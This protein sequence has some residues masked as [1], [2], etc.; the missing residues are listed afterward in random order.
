MNERVLS[1]E[2]ELTALALARAI[3]PGT[4]EMAGADAETVKRALY[5]LRRVAPGSEGA[6]H[7][8]HQTLDLLA[9][10]MAGGPIRDL[11]PHEL[12]CL[13]ASF[14]ET[15]LTANLLH[16]VS[17]VY[18][19]VHFDR[20]DVPGAL[21]SPLEP[22][23]SG[24]PER[25][26][27]NAHRA[28]DL[29]EDIECDVVVV[30]TG[31]GG[32]VVGHK[33]ASLGHAVVF[34]EEGPLFKRGDFPG[35]LVGS[36]TRLYRTTLTAGNASLLIPRGRLVGGSTAVNGGSTFRPP[37][38][39]TQRWNMDLG[40]NE[41]SYDNLQKYFSEVEAFLGVAP[42]DD[43]AAGPFHQI[44][45]A[46][47]QRLGWHSALML[48]N[49][50]GCRGEGFCDNGC[51]SGARRSMDVSYIPSALEKGALLLTDFKVN[52]ILFTRGRARGV[53]GTARS[54]DGVERRVR[55]RARAVVLACGALATPLLLMKTPLSGSSRHLGKHLT[56]HPSAASL[57]LFDVPIDAANYIPQAEFSS[58]FVHEGLLLV[59]AQPDDHLIPAMLPLYGREL[60]ETVRERRYIG[61][62]GFLGTDQGEGSIRLL[63]GGRPLVS[64]RLNRKD[65]ALMK[66]GHALLAR[67]LFASGAR[68]VYPSLLRSR[69]V[70]SKDA[71]NAFE[72]SRLRTDQLILTAFHPLGTCR[73]SP[74]EQGGVVDL[75]H[76]VYGA[77]GLFIADGSV[78]RGPLGV[79]P[80]LSIM[81]WSLRAAEKIAAQLP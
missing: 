9:R 17:S 5:F 31:A 68:A 4:S 21:R 1:S 81:A 25:W 27:R 67:L 57:G 58:Q 37:R 6:F 61:G 46:G 40:S 48:R 34:V 7:A 8:V 74:T 69:P 2:A 16:I 73:M 53:V 66:R 71:L 54:L 15:R 35:H 33:L 38:F 80:Q 10:V 30:G 32:A 3:I 19:I 79:N 62:L 11:P 76:Q 56:I 24:R 75:D 49:A 13:V 45:R 60:M 47:C 78:V 29:S 23:V 55:V 50:P 70:F 20:T 65:V 26:E 41:F 18:K 22:I 36:F 52:D 59:S 39:V 43:K 72:E 64:Y 51:R 28:S 42:A 12:A 44:F 63:P 77:K 14:S